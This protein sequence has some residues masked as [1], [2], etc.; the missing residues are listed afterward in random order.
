MIEPTAPIAL[1]QAGARGA[2]PG[3]SL[4]AT[5]GAL[6]VLA[7]DPDAGVRAQ[8]IE[9]LK[10]LP[11]LERAVTQRTHP[12]ILEL[13]VSIRAEPELDEVIVH[14]RAA[15]ER[16][17]LTIAERA[18]A[19]LCEV[20]SDNHTRLLISPTIAVALHQNPAC[21]EVTLE[22]ALSFLRMNDE[23]P[24]LP[25]E[26]GAGA[27]RRAAPAAPQAAPSEPVFDLEAEIAAAL[28]G[29]ASPMLEARQKLA[30]FDVESLS[31]GLPGFSFD[32]KDEDEDF[33]MEMLDDEQ[34]ADDEVRLTI[35]KKIR[36]MSTGKK[37]KLAFLGN[38]EVR[39]ILIRD[40]SKMVASAVVKSG[41]MTDSEV[42]ANA[43]NRN[44]YPEILRDIAS[45]KE[46]IRK[47]PVQVALVAN[48]R[49]PISVS[50]GMVTRLAEKDLVSLSRNKN[51]SSV[52]AQMAA[53]ILKDK[54]H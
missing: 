50:V 37:I 25:A 13:L 54:A 15:N 18:N 17:V 53:K 46:W 7:C 49:T 9:S 11:G 40:R 34:K 52:L 19:K 41:R 14:V 27:P 24:E 30:M 48:P 12:K 47:Y 8:A 36:G 21:P 45:N 29:R 42:L 23:L 5:L 32:F 1:R 16:T 26:R 33:S 43:A 4:E 2:L 31:G 28:E 38:K 35:E 22:R 10:A 44:L 3:A 20:I 39:N 6:Y 51:V